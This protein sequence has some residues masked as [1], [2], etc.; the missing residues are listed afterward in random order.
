[1]TG[2]E[3]MKIYYEAAEKVGMDLRD[4]P[5][6]MLDVTELIKC[7]VKNKQKHDWIAH[8]RTACT[9]DFDMAGTYCN[10]CGKFYSW[11]EYSAV[12]EWNYCPMCGEKWEVK[13]DRS[14]DSK[15]NT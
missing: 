12:G 5:I 3:A 15:Q 14:A 7:L 13:H 10:K 4:K 11:E 9:H 1:M 8:E 6:D 2:D